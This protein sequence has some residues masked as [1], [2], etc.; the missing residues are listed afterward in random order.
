[1]LSNRPALCGCGD[2]AVATAQGCS[3]SGAGGRAREWEVSTI[4]SEI[5]KA[6]GVRVHVNP[7]DPE[8]VT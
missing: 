1:V 3:D 5:G 8:K 6:L 2:A 4:V 7:K